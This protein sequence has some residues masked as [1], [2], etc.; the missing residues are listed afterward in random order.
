MATQIAISR[1]I[2]RL[3][4]RYTHSHT[5]TL[6]LSIL[7]LLS[8]YTVHLPI[9]R[10]IVRLWWR[11]GRY[12]GIESGLGILSSMRGIQTICDSEIAERW[13]GD[14]TRLNLR[15]EGRKAGRQ[16][17]KGWQKWLRHRYCPP[18]LAQIFAHTHKH[19]HKH[20]SHA[21]THG[22]FLAL[23]APCAE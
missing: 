5:H 15:Q 17:G 14:Q 18:I 1:H 10:A 4:S 2:R 11:G 22:R 6:S 20:G 23:I 16:E 21:H 8:L 12:G 9:C 13:E 3:L 7:S 19:K